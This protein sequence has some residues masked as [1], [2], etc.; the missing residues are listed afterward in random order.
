MSF[1][2][3]NLLYV[4]VCQYSS[5]ARYPKLLNFFDKSITI[6]V[7]YHVRLKLDSTV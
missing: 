6:G 5:T 2:L 7:L 1:G 4:N 3:E